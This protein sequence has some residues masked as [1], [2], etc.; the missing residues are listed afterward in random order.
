MAPITAPSNTAPPAPVTPI[1]PGKSLSFFILGSSL[2]SILTRLKSLPHFYPTIDMNY[3]S[4][5][6]IRLPVIITLPENGVRLR[7]DGPDQRLRLIEVLEDGFARMGITY[8]GNEVVKLGP[9]GS[10]KDDENKTGPTFRHVYHRLFG[11]SYPGEYLPPPASSTPSPYG[12]YILSYP[13]VAFC[14][15]LLHSAWSETCDFV[16]LLSSSAALPAT[17]MSIFSGKSWADAR[18]ELY[19]RVPPYPRNA[20]SSPP[21]KGNSSKGSKDADEV[22]HVKIHGAGKVEVVR[23]STPPFIITLN[24]TTPIDLVAELGP[25]DAIC[26]KA[27]RRIQIHKSPK[28]TRSESTITTDTMTSLESR[29]TDVDDVNDIDIEDGD[30]ADEHDE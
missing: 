22:E 17:A 25:P 26:P 18:R 23:R 27:D 19:T 3:S 20:T 9:T 10:G 4:T 15:P 14:F 29:S 12:T 21:T 13:G 2:H 30:H 11:P 16:S 1:Y 7:F 6:P 8:K 5:D 28:R 24:E